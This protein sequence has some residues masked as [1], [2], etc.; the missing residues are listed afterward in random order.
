[1]ATAEDVRAYLELAD[2]LIAGASK[3]DLGEAARLLAMNLAH[4]RLRYGDLP[5]EN[6]VDMMQAQ[7]VDA[8]TAELLAAGMEQLVGV[9]GIIMGLDENHGTTDIH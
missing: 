6:F 7:T 1:M 9:L 8:E 2:Q 3:E 4:Y 5:L